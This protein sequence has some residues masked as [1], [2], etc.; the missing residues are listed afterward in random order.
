MPGGEPIRLLPAADRLWL[1]VSTVPARDYAETALEAGLQNLD[2]LGPR[3]IAHEAVVE[4]FLPCAAV[5]PMKLFT[6]FK[7]D[8]RAVE[9]VTRTHK[10]IEGILERIERHVE[11]GLRLTWVEQ[12]AMQAAQRRHGA[13]VAASGAAYLARKRDLLDAS[14]SQWTM[15][16]AAAE[17]LYRSAGQE[18]AASRR[19][20]D[21]AQAAPQSHVLLDAAFLVRAEKAEAFR[22]LLKREAPLLGETGIVATL[23]GPW[24]PYNFV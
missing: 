3:A 5:L 24:P 21:K 10:R 23:T 11:W 18:A 14:R 2:W 17:R 20:G 6:L 15:A 8:E 22:A 7:S 13:A 19:H 1:A 12:A 4:H 9:H 16:Q